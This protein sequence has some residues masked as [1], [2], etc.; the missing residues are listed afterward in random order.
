MTI[1]SKKNTQAA[2]PKLATQKTTRLQQLTKL[3]A[4]NSGVTIA[5]VQAAFEWQPHTARAA[6]SSLRK[7]GAMI[8]RSASGKCAVYRLKQKA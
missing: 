8:E 6:I 5:Q 7:G 3:L 2:K 1:D 4:R